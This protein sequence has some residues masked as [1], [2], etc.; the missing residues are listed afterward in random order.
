MKSCLIFLCLGSVFLTSVHSAPRKEWTKLILTHHWPQSFCYME[1]CTTNF[2]YWTLH[3]LWPNTGAECN[4]SWHFN[5]SLIED[6]L[7]EMRTFWP[8]LLRPKSTTFWKHEWMKHGT[9]AAKAEP[10]DSQHK[11]F[12]KALELYHKL[13]LDGVLK[14]NNIVPS[15][16]YYKLTDVEGSIASSYGA[17]PK[18]QCISHKKESEFQVLG[19]IEICFDKQFQL[20]DCEKSTDELQS[21]NG[22]IQPFIFNNHAV[23]AVCDPLVPVYYPPLGSTLQTT[24]RFL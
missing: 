2:T 3:G 15:E 10:M 7:P 16:N 20:V 19:Q 9:C 6:L 17:P 24:P 21:R 1:N 14:K 4:T 12:S 13:D 8:D 18:I 23:Y 5:A 22:E 11:Y